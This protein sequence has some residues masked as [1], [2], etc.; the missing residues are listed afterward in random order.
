MKLPH[1]SELSVFDFEDLTDEQLSG[2]AALAIEDR[3]QA[4]AFYDGL[5]AVSAIV[6]ANKALEDAAH[7][8]RMNAELLADRMKSAIIN[9]LRERNFKRVATTAG[10]FARQ[11]NGGKLPVVLAEGMTPEQAPP[12]F[13]R[14]RFEF[15]MDKI[16]R[17]LGEGEIVDFAKL[18]ERGEHLRLR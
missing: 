10:A 8:R 9:Q 2:A 12:E 16:A 7:T 14:T 5:Q 4:D 6:A 1:P 13:V 15:D 11:A 17:A 18:G 3:E